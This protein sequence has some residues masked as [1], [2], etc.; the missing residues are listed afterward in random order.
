MWT[1][2]R[3]INASWIL[4]YR[5]ERKALDGKSVD[6]LGNRVMIAAIVLAAGKS[7]RMR[8]PKMILPW[9][10]T[11]VIGQ[12]VTT[13]ANAGL[14]KIVLVTGGA[15]REVEL[16]VS[17]MPFPV[18]LVYN[19]GYAEGEMIQSIQVGLTSLDERFEAALF[20]LGD[21]PQMEMGVVRSILVEYQATGSPLIV[22]SY[23]MRRGHPWLVARSLWPALL[24]LR[25]PKTVRDF[26]NRLSDQINYVVVETDS[27]LQ[28]LDTP[29]DYQRYQSTP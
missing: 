21:Q 14:E 19:P 10:D 3:T 29:G 13:L 18:S 27:I 6:L 4:A 20:T 28:D 8:R 12:V 5:N 11:T 9:G 17:G 16:A 25:E 7:V 1:H 15:K 2:R 26:L 23:Q 24:S 22:P